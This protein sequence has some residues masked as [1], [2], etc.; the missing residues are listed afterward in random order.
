MKVLH[1]G[2]LDVRSGG[3]A[4]ST[5]LTLLGLQEQGIDAEIVMYEM[6]EGR[7]LRGEEAKVHFAH[8]PL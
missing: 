4:M 5:Y 3:P 1:T 6:S 7:Q 8:R 2:S